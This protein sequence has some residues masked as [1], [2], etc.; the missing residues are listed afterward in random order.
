MGCS[1][2]FLL[3]KRSAFREENTKERVVFLS[4]DIAGY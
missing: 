2:F 1:D 4:N 3:L